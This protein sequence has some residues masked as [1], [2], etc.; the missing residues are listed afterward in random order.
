[1]NAFFRKWWTYQ[2]ER[3]PVFAHGLLIL[4]FSFSAVAFSALLRGGM[5]TWS[6][7]AV[8]FA[9]S[10]LAFLQLRIADE[11]KDAREDAL[12]RPYR[13]V[14]RGLITLRELGWLWAGTA[15][16]QAALALWLD[17]R[18]L[19]WLAVT[20]TWLALMSR[21]FFV[22]EWL[23]KQPVITLFSH[24]FIMPLIDFYAT[25][26]DWQPEA[27]RAPQGLFWFVAV[28]FCNGMVIEI[29]RKIRGLPEEEKGVETYTA[30]WG[31]P[32]AVAAW[33][34]ALVTTLVCAWQAGRQID[35]F[36]PVVGTLGILLLASLVVGVYF[37]RMPT[38]KWSGKFEAISG[39]WTLALYLLL[40]AIPLFFS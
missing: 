25:A 34:L 35:F 17:V 4:A 40:G 8:A 18:L 39:L 37:L 28:S 24:M 26:C 23:R 22:S 7:A 15:L 2:R 19:P 31:R 13:P 32:M 29:G 36:L 9:N 33:W 11:F 5:P 20:W 14:P 1:M 27:G 3:F 12:H 10:F 38:K 30:L 6:S 21:E 16:V